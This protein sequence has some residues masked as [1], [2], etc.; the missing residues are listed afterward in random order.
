[1]PSGALE[2]GECM[3]DLRPIA[4]GRLILVWYGGGEAYWHERLLLCQVQGTTWVIATPDD[5]VYP[6]DIM[7]LGGK[8]CV[9]GSVPP[10]IP[11]NALL[12]RFP[13]LDQLRTNAEWRLAL[14]AIVWLL[15]AG[16]QAPDCLGASQ[17]TPHLQPLAPW[18][19]PRPG[20]RR[21]PPRPRSLEVAVLSE[22]EAEA[23]LR[24]ERPLERP[25]P[26][27]EQP[28]LARSGSRSPAMASQLGS[29]TL[30]LELIPIGSKISVL[31]S[32]RRELELAVAALPAP[33]G[34]AA[35]IAGP[36]PAAAGVPSDGQV[37]T[38]DARVLPVLCDQMGQRFRPYADGVGLLE[39]PPWKDFPIQGPR[40]TLW[41]CKFTRQKWMREA[42][43]PDNDRVKHEHG[44]LMEIL[45][46]A[47]TYDQLGV[48]AL[49][50][51]ELL[52]RKVQ[53]LEEAY[54]ANPKAPRFEGGEHFQ[55]LGKKVAA[56][57]PQLTSHVALQLQGEA[58][59]QKERRKAREEAALA[60]KG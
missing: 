16:W 23:R 55:G 49:A 18:C 19:P 45:E 60:R 8:P 11:A 7:A 10:A 57:A 44:G 24:L 34:L 38:A 37:R 12:Y 28:R 30:V 17:A 39:E 35:A 2:F 32:R 25:P 13:P 4:P 1:G 21:R 48:S 6:E 14:F 51:V 41:L 26:W 54:T 43:I 15:T 53:L 31:E 50:S 3:G 56:A 36:Q 33:G 58:H 52:S 5:D 20:C 22:A 42:H 47:L 46:W 29:A 59:I 40:A 27:L 9:Q